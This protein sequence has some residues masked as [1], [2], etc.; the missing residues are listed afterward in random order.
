[1]NLAARCPACGTV[2]RIVPDQLKISDGWVRCG[3]CSEVF[4]ARAHMLDPEGISSE[5]A[6]ASPL[7]QPTVTTA[8]ATPAFVALKTP[9]A[10]EPE[11]SPDG[12]DL[13][14]TLPEKD[15][16]HSRTS[17]DGPSARR[18]VPEESPVFEGG[19]FR[20]PS[21]LPPG[22]PALGLQPSRDDGPA[23]DMA[24]ER[25]TQRARPSL[26]LTSDPSVYV[27]LPSPSLGREPASGAMQQR[28]P[29]LALASAGEP[30]FLETSEGPQQPPNDDA[31]LEPLPTVPSDSREPTFDA[32]PHARKELASGFEEPNSSPDTT[33]MAFQT[34]RFMP[35]DAPAFVKTATRRAF[36]KRPEVRLYSSAALIVLV[37]LLG[38]QFVRIYHDAIAAR[39]PGLRAPLAAVCRPMGCTIADLRRIDDIAVDNAAFRRLSSNTYS[40][41]L[42]LRNRGSLPIAVPWIEL[43]LTDT[44][45]RT[46]VRRVLSP[47]ELGIG[48]D[49]LAASEERNAQARFTVEVAGVSGYRVLA[50]YP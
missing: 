41:G 33:E 5:V 30:E 31:P 12:L 16:G 6:P 32:A 15:L 39:F 26:P 8:D 29:S 2:F 46:L 9:S 13:P 42:T 1:M 38:L 37:V 7:K 25:L 40:L 34:S 22:S 11:L 3:Y 4:D 10:H 27:P 28:P 20:T 49:V 21:P 43:S 50:F 48:P 17:S 19:M 44:D 36:W 18:P 14:S 23:W 24:G 35:E 45:G 47:Q